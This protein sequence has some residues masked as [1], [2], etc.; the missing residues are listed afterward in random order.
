MEDRNTV[1][2]TLRPTNVGYAN[3]LRRSI[4]TDIIILGFRADMTENGSTIDVKVFKNTT[5]MSN[6]MLADRIGLLPIAM[7]ADALK[8]QKEKILFRLKVKNDTDDFRLV[9][10]SDFEC[11]ESRADS[12]DLVRIPNTEFFHPHPITLE[13]CTIAVLKPKDEIHLEAYSTLGSGR[14]HPR[15]NPTC[16]CSYKYSLDSDPIRIKMRLE[17]WLREQKMIDPKDLEKEPSKR[18]A[19]ISEFSSL[20]LYRVYEVDAEGEPVS[21]DFSVE[22]TGTM[23]VT[24]IVLEGLKAVVRRLEKYE[25]IENVDLPNVDIRPADAQMKGFDFIIKGEDHTLGNVLQTWIDENEMKDGKIT[26][27]GY[28]VPHPLVDEMVLRIGV[29]DGKEETA[30]K[31]FGDSVKALMDMYATWA[32]EWIIT[33]KNNALPI[34][35]EYASEDT[36]KTVWAAHSGVKQASAVRKT[37]MKK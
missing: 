28:K 21:F 33:M 18:D 4:M 15:F 1:K 34:P 16:Q 35:S 11:L 14:E 17:N 6:E 30:R 37:G 23:P 12:E 25:D 26:F 8:W 20:E 19:L 9:T 10:A 7:P 32:S 3:T 29:E 5:P 24:K 13:T 31:V 27:V 2:F 36:Q 22:S